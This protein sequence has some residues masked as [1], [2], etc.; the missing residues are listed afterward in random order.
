MVAVGENELICDF[1]ET[2]HVLDWRGLPLKT[3]A[4]LAAGLRED[5]RVRRKLT[6]ERVSMETALMAAMLDRLKLL[7]WQN[8]EDGLHGKNMPSSTYE[9]LT[10][11]GTQ[12]NRIRSFRS[13]EDFEAARDRIIKG[14]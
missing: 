14:G 1:A 13:P 10:G 6:G 11:C 12:K 9:A 2:Y 4:I 8:T 7:V 3:A 5:S